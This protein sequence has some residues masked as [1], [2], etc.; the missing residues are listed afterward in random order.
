ML[1]N[2]LVLIQ[3]EKYHSENNLK[4]IIIWNFLTNIKNIC[5][6]VLT[7]QSYNQT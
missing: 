5:V 2:N 7:S 1:L 6:L 4:N 3:F